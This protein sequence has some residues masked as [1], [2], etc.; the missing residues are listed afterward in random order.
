[1]ESKEK[2][3]E[4]NEIKWTIGEDDDDSFINFLEYMEETIQNAKNKST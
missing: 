1:M 2:T 3:N 4:I